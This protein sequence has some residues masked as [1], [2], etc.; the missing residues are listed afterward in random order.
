MIPSRSL[1]VGHVQ[2]LVRSYSWLNS[3]REVEPMVVDIHNIERRIQSQ[4][5]SIQ[6]SSELCDADKDLLL[7][8][9]DSM[10]L[11]GLRLATISSALGDIIRIFKQMDK[12]IAALTKED[13]KE[14]VRSLELSSYAAWTKSGRKIALKR[15]FKWYKGTED[16]EYPDEVKWLKT[17]IRRSDLK[18]VSSGA[19]ISAE[20]Y[21]KL[22]AAA[23]NTR[24]RALIAC[25]FESGCRIGEIGGLTLGAL[26]CVTPLVLVLIG[27]SGA[28][29]A[30]ALAGTLQQSFRWMLFI[31][32]ATLFLVAAIFLQIR[33]K[34]GVCN[35]KTIKK[36][37][38]YVLFTFIF[39]LLTWVALLY[40]IVPM[41]FSL[42][43]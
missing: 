3:H 42:I 21:Q 34:E 25:L 40:V 16:N 30:M 2:G 19:L 28:S 7:R 38:Y 1:L 22:L 24:D 8:Y 36:Y 35:V 43:S 6:R 26:C 37:K 17:S 14:Y 31:P 13:I 29:S 10:V 32:L 15:F 23:R 39:A 33:K 41:G 27:L 20:E 18:K 4:V 12:P 5:A 9:Y 11:Q